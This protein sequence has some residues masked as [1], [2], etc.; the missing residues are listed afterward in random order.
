MRDR[1]HDDVVND[2]TELY[3]TATLDADGTRS[4]H[5]YA[6]SALE[7]SIDGGKLSA[8]DADRGELQRWVNDNHDGETDAC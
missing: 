6:A 3:G 7:D 2:G 4:G 8:N 5:G 1:H